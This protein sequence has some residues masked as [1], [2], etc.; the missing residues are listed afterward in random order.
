[1]VYIAYVNFLFACRLTNWFVVSSLA[2][3]P[4]ACA[5]LAGGYVMIARI[6]LF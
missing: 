2:V 5:S 4:L 6:V 3:T 1:M